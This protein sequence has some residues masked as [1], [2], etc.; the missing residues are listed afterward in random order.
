MVSR[1][2]QTRP[3]LGGLD[4]TKTKSDQTIPITVLSSTG[5]HL[6]WTRTDFGTE[7]MK[8]GIG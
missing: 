2:P 7:R 1:Y 5:R 4:Q 6:D 3:S 8:E